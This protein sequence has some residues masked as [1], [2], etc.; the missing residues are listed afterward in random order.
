MAGTTQNL[1]GFDGDKII[2]SVGSQEDS[3][4]ART[5]DDADS[6]HDDYTDSLDDDNYVPTSALFGSAVLAVD[7][8]MGNQAG[9]SGNVDAERYSEIGVNPEVGS[10]FHI[11]DPDAVAAND[12]DE[13]IESDE[14]YQ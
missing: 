4:A 9:L 3:S 6:F 11:D 14:L 8:P 2:S 13:L 1:S 10:G 7:Q 5:H 12:D